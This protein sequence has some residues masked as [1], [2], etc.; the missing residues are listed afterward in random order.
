MKK[1][2]YSILVLFIL[3]FFN[4]CKEN[5]TNPVNIDPLLAPLY[6][7]PPAPGNCNEGTLKQSEKDKVLAELNYIRSLHGLSAVTYNNSGDKYVQ[8]AA[9]ITAANNSLNHYPTTLSKCYS[10]DG[11]FGCRT[12]NLWLGHANGV[13]LWNSTTMVDDWLDDYQNDDI[14]HRRWL[15]NPFLK[16]VSFG[17]VDY[18]L[19]KDSLIVASAI[20]IM[21]D[22]SGTWAPITLSKDYVAFPEGNYPSTVFKGDWYMSFTAIIDKNSF[23]N[24]NKVDYSNANV[25]ITD[26][27]GN[28]LTVS[29]IL[30]DAYNEPSSFAVPNNIQWMVKTFSKNIKYNVTIANVK[31]NGSFKNY[32]Y[33]FTIN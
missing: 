15:L 24:N 11:A 32:S 4:S 5:S 25:I 33:S 27:N 13:M 23:W 10:T 30:Y 9:L 7:T 28:S 18:L 6:D 21:Q 14:G 29:N 22:T 17:R 2:F 19:A 12:G 3:F 16:S 1:L 26:D 20:Q 31:V 8:K